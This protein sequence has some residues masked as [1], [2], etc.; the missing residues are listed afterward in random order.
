MF[1]GSDN[2][3]GASSKILDKVLEA[4][5]GYTHGYGDDYWTKKAVDMLKDFFDCDLEAYFVS[6]GTAANSLALSSLVKPW[7][8][9][10]CH[11]FGHVVNDESTAPEFF[12]GGARFIPLNNVE[13]KITGKDLES[14]LSVEGVDIPHNSMAKAV[15]ITQS[16]EIGLVYSPEEVNS[17]SECAKRHDLYFHMDGARFA[18]AVVSS[19]A[20]PAELTWKS[21][22]DILSLGATKCG[23][24][25]AEAVIFFNRNCAVD[26]VH[27]RKRSGHLVSKGRMFGSQ[28]VGWLENDHWFDLAEHANNMALKLWKRL[29]KIDCVKIAW[30]VQANEVFV[31]L[32]EVKAAELRKEGAE[33]Y[34]W[35]ISGIPAHIDFQEGETFIRLVSSFTS[36][37]GHIE[38]FCE[39]LNR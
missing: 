30:P 27:R 33:F 8:S 16:S 9:V 24:L 6:T 7:E 31:V 20:S 26:F 13:G 23:A 14:Y 39:I 34:D 5:A 32:P 22:V 11:P 10:L 1:F 4:N 21:G 28:F 35:P 17:I 36:E 29:S 19:K 12:T 25:C 37:D 38:K 2:Q 3:A 18:N 15:T